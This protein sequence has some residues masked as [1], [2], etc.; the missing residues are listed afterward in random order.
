MAG[1]NIRTRD[2]FSSRR[3]TPRLVGRQNRNSITTIHVAKFLQGSEEAACNFATK[4]LWIKF[5]K[6]LYRENKQMPN[7]LLSFRPSS[8]DLFPALVG[9]LIFLA[10][11][12]HDPLF[13]LRGLLATWF[14]QKIAQ[15]F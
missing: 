4:V 3:E 11:F 8:K 9:F 6:R 14:A 7:N 5:K 1:E 15:W 12:L 10:Q 13:H 2:F